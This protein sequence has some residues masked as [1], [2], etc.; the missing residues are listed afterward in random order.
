MKRD[1]DFCIVF[2]L[3]S[4]LHQVI[5]A[6]TAEAER[7]GLRLS[8]KL[9][10]TGLPAMIMGDP[11][12]LRQTVSNILSNALESSN[13]GAILVSVRATRVAYTAAVKNILTI[14][15][16]DEGKG[17]TE[18]KLDALF[19]QFEDILDEDLGSPTPTTRSVGIGLGLAVAARFVR[20]SRGQMRMRSK[21]DVGTEVI[22]ELP[23][24]IGT[25]PKNPLP[26]PPTDT[27]PSTPNTPFPVPSSPI[28][29]RAGRLSSLPLKTPESTTP[30]SPDGPFSDTQRDGPSPRTSYPFPTVTS[31]GYHSTIEP[32]SSTIAVSPAYTVSPAFTIS[33]GSTASP[34]GDANVNLNILVAED[35]PLNAKV[36]RHQ[37]FK[38]GHTVTVVGDGQACFDTFKATPNQFD[39]ILMDFQV[40]FTPLLRQLLFCCNRW[41]D[42]NQM[43]LIDGPTSTKLIREYESKSTP[44]LSS[45]AMRHG[46]IP[47]FAVSASLQEEKYAEYVQNEFDG[48]I[49]KP[50]NFRRVGMLMMGIWDG[51]KRRECAYTPGEWENGGWFGPRIN[52]NESRHC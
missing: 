32:I 29:E 49:L 16:K 11:Q 20:N 10:V 48:W 46:C 22:L 17:M 2:S 6:F 24:N 31:A 34:G 25:A 12:R 38:M 5:D 35:N 19:Q 52:G 15:I 7:K 4:L 40:S 28:S 27:H 50:I 42:F 3:R 21:K 41:T 8:L 9:D 30:Y 14:T 44:T 26:T 45:L 33:P 47:I 39:V 23:L 13:G 36:L 18:A 1:T 51:E 37:L 43:P